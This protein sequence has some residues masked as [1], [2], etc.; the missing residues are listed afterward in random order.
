MQ[1]STSSD[2][3][4]TV[5]LGGAVLNVNDKG[6]A[7]PLKA[8]P[9]DLASIGECKKISVTCIS[10]V[11]WWDNK[12]LL[13]NLT[14]GGGPA[15]ADQW[16]SSWDHAN[17]AGSCS[18]V[19]VENLDGSRVKFLVDTGWDAAYMEER[20]KAEGVDRMLRN[21]EIAFLYLTHEHLDHF[22]GIEAVLKYRPDIPILMPSTFHAPALDYLNGEEFDKPGI[23]NTIPYTGEVI[24]LQ[25]GHMTG[26]MSGVV[27]AGFDVPIILK[28]QGEQSL[29][30][31]VKDAGLVLFTG[32]CHQNIITFAD[33]AI[34]NLNARGKLYGV[35]GGLHL[36]P[37]GS[38]GEKES[39]WIDRIATYGFKKIAA[40]HCT[41]ILA[42]EKMHELG[43]P[44]VRGTGCKGSKSDLHMGN[45]DRIEF[46]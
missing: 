25:V 21:G 23:R 46:G 33:Y 5:N 22:W 43:Y 18:M 40:N 35:Y 39:G 13:A 17:A 28:V 12:V 29:Y 38:L 24:T 10:E 27:S 36:A 2:F 42:I 8:G 20:F 4:R 31:N 7:Q 3:A 1:E 45:G 6:V 37:F 26:L 14:E 34:A 19:E 30:F 16:N 15:E 32:C 9:H 11:G 44:V 41:G